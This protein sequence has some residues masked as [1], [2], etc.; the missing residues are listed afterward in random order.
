MI[1]IEQSK[2]KIDS[3]VNAHNSK[4]V[5]TNIGLCYTELLL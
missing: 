3:F 4:N 1:D 2:R 5:M